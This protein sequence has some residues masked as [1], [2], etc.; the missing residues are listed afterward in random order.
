MPGGVP[1]HEIHGS[2]RAGGLEDL[3]PCLWMSAGLVSY[4][5]CDRNFDCERCPFDAALR[6]DSF[7]A[8]CPGG[9]LAGAPNPVA[10]FYFPEDRL[11]GD[12]HTWVSEKPGDRIRVGLDAFAAALLRTAVCLI[13]ADGLG[14][15]EASVV[16]GAP[17]CSVDLGVGRLPISSPVTGGP[18]RWNGA[19]AKDATILV[20]SPY[21]EGW[22]VQMEPVGAGAL[23]GLFG[24][25]TM[26]ERSRLDLRRFR[27]RAAMFLF[28]DAGAVGPTM[29]DGGQVLTDLRFILGARRYLDLVG[30]LVR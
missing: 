26:L 22:I 17:L 11:Y 5:L 28:D 29:A 23:S 4:K 7:P 18:L 14:G 2:A 24:A 9:S 21:E 15:S 10:A 16:T 25:D 13:P 8:P 27:R 20:T 19:V 30:D 1:A 3:L 12:G 6:G